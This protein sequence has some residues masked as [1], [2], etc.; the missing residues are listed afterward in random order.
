MT[1]SGRQQ[2]IVLKKSDIADDLPEGGLHN[3]TSIVRKIGDVTLVV[4]T[5][6]ENTEDGDGV[7][8]VFETEV[9]PPPHSKVSCLSTYRKSWD[10]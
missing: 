7:T 2:I 3:T 6:V 4:N 8:I 5:T 10:G 9:K 1:R